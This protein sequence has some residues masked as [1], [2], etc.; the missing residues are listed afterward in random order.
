MMTLILVIHCLT[1]VLLVLAVLMQAGRGGGLTESFS[2]AESVFGAQT[3]TFMV[4]TT[5]I[6]AAIFFVTSLSLAY[7]SSHQAK[8]LM[9]TE[10][11]KS[12]TVQSPSVNPPSANETVKDVVTNTVA[13]TANEVKA[14]VPAQPAAQ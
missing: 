10:K 1:C 4:R 2:S 13:P 3:S 11:Q 6:L 8:S 12:K 9:A 7:I 14:D 5:S